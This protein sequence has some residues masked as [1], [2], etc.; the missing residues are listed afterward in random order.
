MSA[1]SR[2]TRLNPL[3]TVALVENVNNL[4][5]LVVRAAAKSLFQN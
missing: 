5:E 2:L 1:D 4:G 3:I